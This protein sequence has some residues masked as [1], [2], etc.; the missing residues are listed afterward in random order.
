[1]PMCEKCVEIDKK[2]EHYRRI[3]ASIGD[4]LTISRIRELIQKL[5]VKKASTASRPRPTQRIS[6][7]GFRR[8]WQAKLARSVGR[9]FTVG[10]GLLLERRLQLK[11][12]FLGR[13]SLKFESILKVF[14]DHFHRRIASTI[15]PHELGRY[16]VAGWPCDSATVGLHARYPTPS[17][18]HTP[19]YS[20]NQAAHPRH[21]DR[22]LAGKLR[23]QI[24]QPE[25]MC[26]TLRL[27]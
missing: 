24:G 26:Q 18:R 12:F 4:E 14:C 22:N 1:M 6:V 5:E 25:I 13:H 20:A 3:C 8:R 23:L 9:K 21:A 7:N 15:V 10:D 16:Q 11:V 2:T 17:I 19:L 27:A